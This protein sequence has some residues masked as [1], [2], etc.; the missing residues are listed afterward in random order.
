MTA[1][2]EVTFSAI[3]TINYKGQPVDTLTLGQV[4]SKA[5]AEAAK[6]VEE[7]MREANACNMNINIGTA[8]IKVISLSLHD[9]PTA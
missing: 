7:G 4:Q 6:L 1:T 2:M 8:P 3:I 5:K 9:S